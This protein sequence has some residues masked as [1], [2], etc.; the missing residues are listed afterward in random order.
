MSVPRATARARRSVSRALHIAQPI[1]ICRRCCCT[2][3]CLVAPV[4]VT[5]SRHT[6]FAARR[7]LLCL[8]RPC[9]RAMPSLMPVIH[10][11]M[12]R[13]APCLSADATMFHF[14]RA[15]RN[16]AGAS[17]RRR[18]LRREQSSLSYNNVSHAR[19]A[20]FECQRGSVKHSKCERGARNAKSS[21]QRG[22]HAREARCGAY[23]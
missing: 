16:S 1:K 19:D 13:M 6:C 8:Q 9:R 3:P 23:R 10:M 5:V 4:A 14:Q 21:S 20:L 15:R 17:R 12:A 2:P 22:A 7:C 11:L 18:W